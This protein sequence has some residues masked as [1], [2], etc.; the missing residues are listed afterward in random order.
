MKG[1]PK[2]TYPLSLEAWANPRKKENVTALE[3]SLWHPK[4]RKQAKSRVLAGIGKKTRPIEAPTGVFQRCPVWLDPGKW[5][6][7]RLR[8]RPWSAPGRN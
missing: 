6:F 3:K 4:W 1:G 7:G 8:R 2:R 5:R